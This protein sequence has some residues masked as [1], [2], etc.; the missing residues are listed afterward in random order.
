MFLSTTGQR[1]TLLVKQIE[2]GTSVHSGPRWLSH[3]SLHIQK[4]LRKYPNDFSASIWQPF[5]FTA[6]MAGKSS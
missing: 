4:G 2:D 1:P 3:I 5:V 6:N